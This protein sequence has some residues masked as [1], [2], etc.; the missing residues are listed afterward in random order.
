LLA[1]ESGYVL[2]MMTATLKILFDKCA[3][4]LSKRIPDKFKV[5]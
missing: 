2:Q 4:E 1:G 5:L 3:L